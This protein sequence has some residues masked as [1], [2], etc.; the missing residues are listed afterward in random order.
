MGAWKNLPVLDEPG[1][2]RRARNDGSHGGC[3]DEVEPRRSTSR[4]GSAVSGKD[5][6]ATRVWG[7]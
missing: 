7:G 5:S 2:D 1:L 4:R 3:D 6:D